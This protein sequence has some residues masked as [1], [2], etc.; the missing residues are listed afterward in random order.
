MRKGFVVPVVVQLLT[1][2]SENYVK[3]RRVL[4]ASS[5]C[6]TSKQQAQSL[7]GYLLFRVVVNNNEV[8]NFLCFPI[9]SIP[10]YCT[11]VGRSCHRNCLENCASKSLRS[12]TSSTSS[13]CFGKWS[14]NQSLL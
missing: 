3:C 9:L 2:R 1:G 4:L 5:T 13:T 11:R 12:T 14:N 7:S 8:A 10:P 6:T